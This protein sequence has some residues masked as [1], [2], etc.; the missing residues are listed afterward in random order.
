MDHSRQQLTARLSA[1]GKSEDSAHTPNIDRRT[2]M[3]GMFSLGAAGA[4]GEAVA[5][6]ASAIYGYTDK[7]SYAPGE[8]VKLH[9]SAE[10]F[11]AT[12]LPLTVQ[13]QLR[14][15]V[16]GAVRAS[17]PVQVQ[18]RYPR[19]VA[20]DQQ[21]PVAGEFQIPAGLPSGVYFI[22]FN[23]GSWQR[24]WLI[25]RESAAKKASFLV[26]IPTFTVV[27]YNAFGGKSTYNYNSP[28]GIASK[29]SLARP[30][31][32]AM[33]G[34]W[35]PNLNDMTKWLSSQYDCSYASDTELHEDPT[36]LTGRKCVVFVGH[37]EYYTWE[38]R[39]NIDAYL[40]QGGNMASFG[41][42][43][44]WWLIEYDKATRSI[45]VEKSEEQ[46]NKYYWHRL[47]YSAKVQFGCAF[48]NGA[49]NYKKLPSLD[50]TIFNE[51]HWL[52]D[53]SGAR[54]S[55]TFGRTLGRKNGKGVPLGLASY[56]VD[57]I[58]VEWVQ[59]PK[60]GFL[61]Q[62]K[63][64]SGTPASFKVLA[65]ADLTGVDWEKP[66]NK[67]GTTYNWTT[68]F[69][70]TQW[71]GRVFNAGTIEWGHAFEDSTGSVVDSPALHLTRNFLNSCVA[72]RV[73]YE[74]DASYPSVKNAIRPVTLRRN[75][76]TTS[77]TAPSGWQATDSALL[78]AN[79]TDP[80]AVPL[81]RF[82]KHDFMPNTT[83]QVW[84]E[85][86]STESQRPG[87]RLGGQIGHVFKTQRPKTRPVHVYFSQWPE[88]TVERLSV[89]QEAK[90]GETY[91][92]IRFYV[93]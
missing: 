45:T 24:I 22:V 2:A 57:G 17:G 59:N 90:A 21:W 46:K 77:A 50:A 88:G 1:R 32:E 53:G 38:I 41:G 33:Q 60:G 68:G 86:L 7:E 19:V 87:W 9:L 85:C 67:A 91:G 14:E 28:T 31:F 8:R 82:V 5:Q 40:K 65:F 61:P 23:K 18:A 39:R 63:P 36:L 42:N 51:Q 73:I 12:D 71:G 11:A 84:L 83:R 3:A 80:E 35:Y 75:I 55:Q 81:Y 43:T 49:F 64:N 69:Y 58:D 47:G 74:H 89:R 34:N 6:T 76:Y 20:L 70:H 79:S 25:V 56:E 93:F 54:T 52:Y 78:L 30:N 10:N 48:E 72:G 44:C 92:G 62:A 16:N 66:A 29:V 13:W 4:M 27:A 37:N 15:P 26:V